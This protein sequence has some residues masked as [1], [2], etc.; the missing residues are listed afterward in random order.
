MSNNQNLELGNLGQFVPNDDG[1]RAVWYLELL[2][3]QL[4]MQKTHNLLDITDRTLRALKEFT[5][6]I[7]I[8]VTGSVSSAA[9]VKATSIDLAKNTK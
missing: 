7:S 2:E 5:E 4:G 8:Q 6:K 9:Q 3:S 1:D